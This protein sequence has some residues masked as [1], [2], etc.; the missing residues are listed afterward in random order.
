M[1]NIT[2]NL[3]LWY[4]LDESSG[5]IANDATANHRNGT[6]ANDP[7]WVTGQ[8]GRGLQFVAA[9]SQSVSFTSISR[10]D[11]E[12]WTWAAWVDFTDTG[13]NNTLSGDGASVN[14]A[15]IKSSNTAII[16]RTGA[17]TNRTFTVAALST[18]F[19]H[20][21]VTREA[22]GNISVYVDSVASVSNPISDAGAM[23]FA[24]LGMR[25]SDLF[26]NGTLDDVRI[27]SRALGQGDITA[28]YN[29]RGGGSGRP[30]AGSTG[31]GLF[32]GLLGT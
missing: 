3:E 27:Y 11:A 21:A 23:S 20:I 30:L 5:T 12:A 8:I 1:P 22:G 18:V 10:T 19:R 9:S 32:S 16:V 17:A 13:A 14:N 7:T 29:W 2:S 24:R 6:L 26:L 4:R 15:I 25:N 31:V 28:L